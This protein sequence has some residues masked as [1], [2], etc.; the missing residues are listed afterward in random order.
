[1]KKILEPLK[2]AEIVLVFPTRD[3]DNLRDLPSSN[4]K[5]GVVLR[6]SHVDA[7]KH[8][9]AEVVFSAEIR[10]DKVEKAD[11]DKSEVYLMGKIIDNKVKEKCHRYERKGDKL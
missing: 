7:V 11:Q 6:K 1:M 4:A 5:R 8:G 10:H 2:A 9:K 3:T